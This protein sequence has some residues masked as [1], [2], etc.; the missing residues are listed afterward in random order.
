MTNSILK[1]NIGSE[2]VPYVEQVYYFYDLRDSHKAFYNGTYTIPTSG[3][4]IYQRLGSDDFY[5][6]NFIAADTLWNLCMIV[7]IRNKND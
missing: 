2:I 1:P 4:Y 3:E 7:K 6:A 5:I